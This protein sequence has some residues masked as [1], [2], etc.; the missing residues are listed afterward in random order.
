MANSKRGHGF[1]FGRK[2]TESQKVHEDLSFYRRRLL[3]IAAK[4][5]YRI[6]QRPIEIKFDEQKVMLLLNM[7]RDPDSGI[8][9][10]DEVLICDKLV[11]PWLLDVWDDG[12]SFGPGS[13]SV[14]AFAEVEG[15][16]R[17]K[18]GRVKGTFAVLCCMSKTDAYVQSGIQTDTYKRDEEKEG[19]VMLFW[20]NCLE[21]S[22]YTKS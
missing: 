7:T 6:A 15:K 19:R 4:Y 22:P 18:G 17:G 20:T 21:P 16:V 8:A 13:F 10:G 14:I 12:L 2:M 1:S 3:K 11:S 5:G 9:I